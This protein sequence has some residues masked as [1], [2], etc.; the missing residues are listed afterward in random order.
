MLRLIRDF[1]FPSAYDLN[2]RR[3][4]RPATT[5]DSAPEGTP[6]TRAGVPVVD[7]QG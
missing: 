6:E 1:F 5:G 2:K 7:R 4:T 3:A